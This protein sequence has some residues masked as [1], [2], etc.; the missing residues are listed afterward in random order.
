MKNKALKWL[1][2]L[3]FVLFAMPRLSIK[4]GPVPFYI[5]D[6]FIFVVFIYSGRVKDRHVAADGFSKMVTAILFFATISEIWGAIRMG[7]FLMPIYQLIRTLLAISL[8]FSVRRLLSTQEDV[9]YV[10]RYAVS[11]AFIS[12]VILIISSLPF[13]RFIVDHTVFAV[14]F[15]E[16]ASTYVV[17]K[18]AGDIDRGVRGRSLIGVSILTGA[19]LNTIYPWIFQLKINK[20][21]MNKLQNWV[22]KWGVYLL[23]LAVVMTYSRGAIL[24][25]M[26]IALGMILFSNTRAKKGIV[27]ALTVG[28]LF[29][30]LV[31]WHSDWFFFSRVTTSTEEFINN[32]LA[33]Q[34]NTQRIFAYSQ[35][36]E[37]L[38]KNPSFLVL[39]VGVARRHV[40]ESHLLSSKTE[41]AI[42]AVFAMAFYSYGFIAAIL[43]MFLLIKSILYSYRLARNKFNPIRTISQTLFAALLGFSS[44]FMLGHAPV[45]AP[46]GAML[47]FLVFGLVSVQKK[48]IR[49]HFREAAQTT[50]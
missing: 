49:N 6:V 5:I 22:N 41:L 30:S 1:G 50:G 17:L 33:K 36:F 39:G 20:H 27:G 24:G 31:G 26:S 18:Y 16:P 48:L 3:L 28:I 9:Q 34:R 4:I 13:T 25:L 45:D 29:F 8:F 12:A 21:P 2:W 46:R 23:P 7:I 42:H 38:V 10:I 15:L 40:P 43:Y 19:F 14:P 32:P 44:W 11:G 35:P 47:L 37:Y